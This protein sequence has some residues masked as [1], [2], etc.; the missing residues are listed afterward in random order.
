MNLKELVEL[1]NATAEKIFDMRGAV[2]PIY[3]MV[4][5]DGEH[6]IVPAPAAEDKDV[7]AA[8]LRAIMELRRVIRF[9]RVDEAWT[10]H[11]A[12]TDA[13]VAKAV[14]DIDSMGGARNHPDRV[15]VVMLVAEDCSEGFQT[16]HRDI[17]RNPGKRAR[18]GPLIRDQYTRSEGRFVGMLPRPQEA[19]VQ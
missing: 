12:V 17:I 9:V 18:L 5:A 16:Y 1:A 2:H 7:S 19:R 11:L 6:F 13:E 4:N 3:F 15:E 8:L 10:V 14:E